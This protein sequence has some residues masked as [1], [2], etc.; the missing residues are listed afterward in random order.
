MSVHEPLAKHDS[1]GNKS[2]DTEYSL[3]ENTKSEKSIY[4]SVHLHGGNYTEN[5]ISKNSDETISKENFAETNMYSSVH[6]ADK[7]LIEAKELSLK[8]PV[9]KSAKSQK[10][11]ANTAKN[12]TKKTV[13]QKSVL[14]TKA[15]QNSLEAEPSSAI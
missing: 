14:I 1:K 12:S 15:N 11:K 13:D 3:G 2:S 4:S 8:K 5:N 7:E 6:L 9:E 10:S